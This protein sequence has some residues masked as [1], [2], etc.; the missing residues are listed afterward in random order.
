MVGPVCNERASVM[1]DDDAAMSAMGGGGSAPWRDPRYSALTVDVETRAEGEVV[2]TC[3]TPIGRV[4]DTLDG[5]LDHWVAQAPSRTWL[6]ER[7]G[8]GWRS[9]SYAEGAEG[10]AAL[11]GGLAAMGLGLG[12]PLMIVAVNGIDAALMTYAAARIGCPVAPITPQYAQPGAEPARLAHAVGLI[13]PAA[14]FVDDAALR[15]AALR[16][17]PLD[18]AAPILSPADLPRLLRGAPAPDLA[19]PGLCAKLLLTS[20]STGAPKAVVMTHANIATNAAQVAACFDDAEPPVV[21]NA[22]PWSHSLGANAIL[23]MVT[24]RGGTLYIDA[25]QPAPG[26]FGETLRNLAEVAPTYHNMVPA[27]WALLAD[28]LEADAGL[29]HTFFSRVRVLQYGGAGLPASVMA[30]VQAV[31]VRGCGERVTFATGY[32][33]TETGPTASNVRWLNDRPGRLGSPLPGT[34]IRLV[35]AEGGKL[36][37]RIRG[38]QL[39][40]GYRQADGLVRPLP[41]DAEGFYATGD[42]GRLGDPAV[43]EQGV[44]FDGRLVEN[45]KL[46]TG[47]FVVA[48][49]LR[50]AAVSAMGP[51]VSDVVVCGENREGVGLLVFLHAGADPAAGRGAVERGLA[52]FNARATGA[53]SR[54]ARALVL[55]EPPHAASGEITDKGYINQA[56]A[57]A[58]RAAE[59]EAL[60]A[61]E[62]DAR[63]IVLQQEGRRP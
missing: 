6:A 3:P 33:S 57:R 2:L 39:S 1:G 53:G 35:P 60:F 63:V 40:P 20:G 31:G 61:L 48:G 37:V 25:G 49:A 43:P 42:A 41:L 12:R 47:A 56:L 54:I 45:F 34:A 55:E 29:A 22:A 14:A 4:F 62:P 13:A 7:S 36:E 8:A 26:R 52:A 15:T 16:A 19:S 21:V 11:A 27:G 30:R 24:H 28:A 58:R 32:G 59:V 23:H 5:P 51:P 38:P 46:V 10:A 44:V 18:A 9:L 50:L 17:S